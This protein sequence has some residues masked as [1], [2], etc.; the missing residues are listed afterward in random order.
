MWKGPFITQKVYSSFYGEN[1][2][3]KIIFLKR[4]DSMILPD[5]IQV[6]IKIYNGCRFFDL[7]I[8]PGMVGY[9]FGCFVFTRKLHVYKAKR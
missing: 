4:K 5:F 3:N 7:C 2:S 9:K 8:S 1:K 6:R